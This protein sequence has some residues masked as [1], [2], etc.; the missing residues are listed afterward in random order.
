MI[1]PVDPTRSPSGFQRTMHKV[2]M[3]TAGRWFGINVGARV[4]PA[5]LR[6]S[7]GRIATT[8][9]F[10]LVLMTVVGRRSG[11]PRTVPLVYFTERDEV[12]LI[13]SSFGRARHPAWYLNAKANP[14]VELFARGRG[15]TY[16]VRETEGAERDRLFALA[17]QLYGGYGLYEERASERLIPVLALRP[18]NT[19]E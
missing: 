16:L 2:G 12:I 14:R 19:A 4:D 15:G 3:S 10:P 8:S 6:L 18:E 11:E 17:K 13:A 7:G 1:S 5:L 9:F